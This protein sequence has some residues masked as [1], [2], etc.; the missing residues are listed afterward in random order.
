MLS[1]GL[2]VSICIAYYYNNQR[3]ELF[4]FLGVR[5][6]RTYQWNLLTVLRLPFYRLFFETGEAQKCLNMRAVFCNDCY[7]TEEVPK[8]VATEL[9]GIQQLEKLKFRYQ[10]MRRCYD[11]SYEEW[12]KAFTNELKPFNGYT[13]TTAV[14]IPISNPLFKQ[15]FENKGTIGLDIPTWFNIQENNPR[16]FI[17][18]QDPLRNEKW[19]KD[20]SDAVISSPFAQHDATHRINGG[21]MVNL[22]ITKLIE[23]KYAIYLTDSIKYFIYDH[24]TT[25]VELSAYIQILKK[26]LD[27]VNPS[28]CVC[29]GNK[30]K[31]ILDKCEINSNSIFFPHLSGTARGSII[32]RFPILKEKA[33]VENIA[34]IYATEIVKSLESLK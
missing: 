22:M 1:F 10:Q 23:E 28:L 20:C 27:L 19:Y 11:F 26:E 29:L 18:A 5:S 32:K 33:T 6:S 7:L 24:K 9:L 17:I 31:E 16:I 12:Q 25:E 2:P 15:S 8:L 13:D 4:S 14:T 34:N 30:A 3:R 21:K